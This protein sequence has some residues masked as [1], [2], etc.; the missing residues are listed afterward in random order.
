MRKFGFSRQAGSLNSCTVPKCLTQGELVLPSR[1]GSFAR[2]R[3][4]FVLSIVAGSVDVIGFLTLDGLFTAHITGNIVILA[5]RFV[6]GGQAP[7]SQ[8]LA[9]PVFMLVLGLTRLL[10]AWLE[11]VRIPLLPT[12]LFLELALLAGFLAVGL[13]TSQSNDPN[14]ASM[15]CAGLLGVAAM[16]VQNALGRTSLTGAPSTAVMTTNITVFAMDIGEILLA[17]DANRVARARERAR[18]TGVAIAGF[19]V[20]CTLG[21]AEEHFF[22]LHSLAIPISFASIALVLGFTATAPRFRR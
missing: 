22:G 9:V 4:P 13:A 2:K 17:P 21:A 7:L 19:V 16:A 8:L 14:A 11:R 12:L 10:A 1:E 20:G 6:A 5:A 15:V 3:L 18:D